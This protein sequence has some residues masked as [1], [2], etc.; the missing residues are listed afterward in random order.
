MTAGKGDYNRDRIGPLSW[1]E[2]LDRLLRGELTGVEALQAGRIEISARRLSACIII[3]AM[4]YG[5]CMGTFALFGTKGPNAYQVLASMVKVP[6]LFYLTLVVTLPSL[7]V[8]NALVGSRLTPSTVIRLLVASLGVIVTVLS[9][10]GPIV[11]FFSVSTTSYPFMVLFNVVVFAVSGALGLTFLLQT[12]HRLSVAEALH[13]LSVAEARR[14]PA[15]VFEALELP[16][17]PGPDASASM[18]EL[19]GPEEPMGPLDPLENRVL[20]GHVKTVFQLWVIVFGLVGAQM[21]W[22][23]RPFI[24]NPNI[25][26]TWFRGRESNF[27]QA[28]LHNLGNLFS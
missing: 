23:L 17:S 16:E 1:F 12:L 13:R 27:F 22:V 15:E 25:P 5:A 20:S 10:L 8:F 11:A 2:E 26:F 14:P 18:A 21:G 24:G 4:I 28:I 6:L 19:P 7:Y 3:L 9:S